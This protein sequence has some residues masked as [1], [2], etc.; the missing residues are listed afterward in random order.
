MTESKVKLSFACAEGN[1]DYLHTAKAKKK[2]KKKKKF[3][4]LHKLSGCQQSCV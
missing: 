4:Q 2:T 1:A 3:T